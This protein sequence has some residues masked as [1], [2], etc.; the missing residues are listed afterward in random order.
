[1]MCGILLE[2]SKKARA[3]AGGTMDEVREA[4]KI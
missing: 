3:V 2:G 4:M 1:M